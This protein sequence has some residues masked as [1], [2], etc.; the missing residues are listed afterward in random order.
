MQRLTDDATTPDTADPDV[1]QGV[2]RLLVDLAVCTD[3]T[4]ALAPLT[5]L[6]MHAWSSGNGAQAGVAI[7]RA[8]AIDPRYSLA[9]LVDGLLR[10]GLEPSWVG[11]RRAVDESARPRRRS[12][13]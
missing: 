11:R 8:L 4:D 5:L 1:H 10:S 2:D 9:V 3:G 12:R 6:A 13:S 7:D